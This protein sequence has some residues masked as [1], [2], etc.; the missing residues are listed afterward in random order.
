M[1]F[2][3]S[4]YLSLLTM[5]THRHRAIRRSRLRCIARAG[6]DNTRPFT[7]YTLIC[8]S[9]THDTYR[10]DDSTCARVREFEKSALE[11]IMRTSE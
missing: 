10:I 7:R 2:Y 4:L 6:I 8:S 9:S 11:H 1:R 5:A 3:F